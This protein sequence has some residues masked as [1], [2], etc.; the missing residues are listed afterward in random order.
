VD[1]GMIV[2]KFLE[3]QLIGYDLPGVLSSIRRRTESGG[4]WTKEQSRAA[5]RSGALDTAGGA[6]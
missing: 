5:E 2:P 3:E 1:S 6:P 4:T